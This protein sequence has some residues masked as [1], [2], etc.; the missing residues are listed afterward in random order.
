MTFYPK[1]FSEN[2]PIDERLDSK[3]K[4]TVKCLRFLMNAITSAVF[5]CGTRNPGVAAH[6]SSQVAKLTKPKLVIGR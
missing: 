2:N 6:K 4:S 5:A 3:E 1:N